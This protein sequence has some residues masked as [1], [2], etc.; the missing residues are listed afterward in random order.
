MTTRRKPG[1]ALHPKYEYM[2]YE[3]DL[4][5]DLGNVTMR[6][7]APEFGVQTERRIHSV[8]LRDAI[9]PGW[10]MQE[11]RFLGIEAIQAGIV[12]KLALAVAWPPLSDSG[13]AT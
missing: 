13:I 4:A 9:S 3:A 8:Q 11:E 10:L 5:T 12:E 1:Y 2:E 6:F 7:A